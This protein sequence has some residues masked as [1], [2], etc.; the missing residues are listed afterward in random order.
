MIKKILI[1]QP[2]P[3]ASKSPYFDLAEKYGV[4]FTF[5]PLISVERV[6]TREFRDQR[7]N[8]LDHTAVVFN[9]RHAVDHFFSLCKE[10]RVAVPEDMKYFAIS[11]TVALYIQKYVQY[12]KR[13]VFFGKTGKMPELYTIMAKHKAERYLVPQSSVHTDE[14]HDALEERKLAHTICVMYR[15]VANKLPEDQPF[16]YDLVIAFTPTGIN[17]LVE[18]LPDIANTDIRIG[19]FGQTTAKAAQ[20]AGIKLALEAPTPE[21]P[22]ITGAIDLFLKANNK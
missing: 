20:E 7:V 3:A 6:S 9:S 16:D 22:S 15:T 17:A 4:E 13:K 14:I 11:E 21:S 1:S 10:L 19:T 2:A 8:I 18:N 12:R 5:Y